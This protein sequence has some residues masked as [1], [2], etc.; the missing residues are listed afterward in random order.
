MSVGVKLREVAIEGMIKPHLEAW[1]LRSSTVPATPFLNPSEFE[2][3]ARLEA[4]WAD[5]RAELDAVLDRYRE[6]PNFQ[7]ITPDVGTITDD[8]NWKSYF[9]FGFG[10]RGTENLASCPRTAELLDQVP[11]LTTAFFSIMAPG[12]HVPEHRGPYRGVLRYHLGLRIPDPPGS[13]GIRVGSEVRHWT[14]GGSLLFD[15]C[16]PHSVWNDGDDVRVVLFIDVQRPMRGLAASFNRVVIKLIKH[17]PFIRQAKR[18][19]DDWE[20]EFNRATPDSAPR[21]PVLD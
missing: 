5:I 7:S 19:Y 11:G 18:N 9:F 20:R 12:K 1:L 8:D 15:D 2:W 4:G 21:T 16:Y 17:S 14:N 13:A 6:F 10:H 3:V